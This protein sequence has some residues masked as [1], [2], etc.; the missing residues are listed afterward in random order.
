MTLNTFRSPTH[1]PPF[2]S[3]IQFLLDLRQRWFLARRCRGPELGGAVEG[4]WLQNDL[5]GL[6]TRSL[7]QFDHLH[8]PDVA[9]VQVHHACSCRE[10]MRWWDEKKPWLLWFHLADVVVGIDAKLLFCTSSSNMDRLSSATFKTLVFTGA[11]TRAPSAWDSDF[12]DSLMGWLIN[13]TSQNLMIYSTL[14]INVFPFRESSAS[15]GSACSF[16][17]K[18][19]V[20]FT[21][22][23]ILWF[24]FLVWPTKSSLSIVFPVVAH[25]QV[26]PESVVLFHC[27]HF[28]CF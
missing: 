1:L 17:G 7:A 28:D 26:E 20:L 22:H 4:G 2:L 21:F 27:R 24:H 19:F 11:L 5:E 25:R 6:A 9:E 14:N 10:R 3:S 8:V 12:Y 16:L 18:Y 13:C 15:K 23:I